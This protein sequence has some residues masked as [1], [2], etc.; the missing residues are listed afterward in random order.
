MI[1]GIGTD[2][3]RIERIA[4]AY[5]RFGAHFVEVG[6]DVDLPL[7]LVLDALE[8]ELDRPAVHDAV[9]VSVWSAAA[10]SG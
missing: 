2:V 7:A 5:Q 10:S 3:V 8:R 6:V 9:G 4:A 1:F